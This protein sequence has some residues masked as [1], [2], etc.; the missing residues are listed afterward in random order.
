MAMSYRAAEDAH[1]WLEVLAEHLLGSIFFP[2]LFLPWTVP[3][4][5]LPLNSTLSGRPIETS[6]TP[7]KRLAFLIYSEFALEGLTNG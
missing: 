6:F 2:L 5:V 4:C 1:C 3:Q 7:E